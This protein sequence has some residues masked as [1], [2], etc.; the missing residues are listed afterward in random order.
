MEVP[1]RID[2]F[3]RIDLTVRSDSGTANTIFGGFHYYEV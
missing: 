1:L 2:G 3:K